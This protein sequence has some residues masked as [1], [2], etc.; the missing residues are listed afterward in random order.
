MGGV[1]RTCCGPT[2]LSQSVPTSY[3]QNGEADFSPP[4]EFNLTAS[5]VYCR[6]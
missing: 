2:R 4:H 5:S 1:H 3:E 6:E